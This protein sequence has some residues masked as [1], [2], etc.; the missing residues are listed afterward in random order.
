MKIAVDA[1]GG[2]NAPQ[3]VIEGVER[4]RDEYSDLEFV[5]YGKIDEIKKCLQNDKNITLVQ[6]DEEI[7]GTDEPV[8]AV[9]KKKN[10]SMVMAAQSVKDGENDAMFSLGN[11]GALLASGI[12]VVGRIKKVERP[13]L[14]TT[15][16]VTNSDKGVLYLDAGANA[17]A[18]VSY[19]EQWA[20]MSNFYAKEIKG[21]KNPRIALLNNGEEFDKGDDLH[22]ETYQRLSELKEINFIGNIESDKL[23][24]GMADIVVTDGFTGNAA[25][26]ALEGTTKTILSLLKHSLT[27]SGIVTKLGAAIVSPALNSMKGTFDVSKSGGAVLLGLKAPVVKAHGSADKR[28]VYYTIGQI[29]DMVNKKIIDQV[30]DYYQK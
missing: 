15:L 13:A 24:T 28:A 5:L 22:K 17:E 7:L 10:S 1:M 19:M 23:L 30:I 25:L 16:P 29:R 6:A 9:R 11:T 2:D 21:I 3:V 18:K 12:F 8:K 4:A 27:E 14:M 20:L 26:K